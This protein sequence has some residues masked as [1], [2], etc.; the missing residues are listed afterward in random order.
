M[1][2]KSW[3]VRLLS[4]NFLGVITKPD[5][6]TAEEATQWVELLNGSFK[7]KHGFFVTKQPSH[8]ELSTNISHGEARRRESEFFASNP[9][10]TNAHF[11]RFHQR[12][13][14][15]QLQFTLAKLLAE[16]IALGLPAIE[17]KIDQQLGLVNTKL[18]DFPA[19]QE[20]PVSVVFKIIDQIRRRVAETT[21][22]E[23]PN[24]ELILA[25]REKAQEYKAQLADMQ[26]IVV[27]ATGFEDHWRTSPTDP[28]SLD[29]DE[30]ASE[31][32]PVPGSKRAMAPPSTP[33][34]RQRQTSVRRSGI[35]PP[36][37][38]LFTSTS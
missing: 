32:T 19:P 4:A 25:W 37:R 26:P 8:E 31:D 9:L 20:N 2:T 11:A 10:W 33:T 1:S 34:K 12:Y 22:G 3:R 18:L 13:G 21:L 24:N 23:Y 5:K 17:R 14:T 6:L 36:D 30:D 38:G 28:I 27:V 15:T 16:E 35:P 7:I 29:S